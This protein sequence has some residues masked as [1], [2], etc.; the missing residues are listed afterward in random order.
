MLYDF[1]RGANWQTFGH[2][3]FVADPTQAEAAIL[4]SEGDVTITRVDV[5][6]AT[7]QEYQT[8]MDKRARM[9]QWLE[10]TTKGVPNRRADL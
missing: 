3:L 6:P 7:E 2:A 9:A 1:R 8:H 4:K 10:N 5:S